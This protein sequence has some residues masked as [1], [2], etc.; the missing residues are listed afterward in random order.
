MNSLKN[1][2]HKNIY[3]TFYIVRAI[4]KKAIFLYVFFI[5]FTSSFT[6]FAFDVLWI[7]QSE[8]S[9]L[10]EPMTGAID[11][12]GL[13][14]HKLKASEVGKINTLQNVAKNEIAVVINAQALQHIPM[15]SLL[16]VIPQKVAILI[17]GINRETDSAALNEWSM[18]NIVGTDLQGI[19]NSYLNIANANWIAGPL[20]GQKIPIKNTQVN[21]LVTR[22]GSDLKEILWTGEQKENDPRLLMTKIDV[23]KREIFF[24]AEMGSDN[25]RFSILKVLPFFMFLKY[26]G[27][28]RSYHSDGYY[29]NLTIDDP[30]LI[31]PYGFLS[32]PELL[33]EMKKEN[34]HTTIAFIPWNYDRSR[35]DVI[36]II[37][38]HADLFSLCIHGNDHDHQEFYPDDEQSKQQKKIQ[39][40][41]ARMEAFKKITGIPYDRVMVFPHGMAPEMTVRMIQK[42]N[43]L[44]TI[45]AVPVPLLSQEFVGTLNG[46]I[47][48]K[49]Q[50]NNM[51]ILWGYPPYGRQSWE[52]GLDLF[53]GNPVLFYT[54][55]DFFETGMNAF[56]PI[57]R[58]VNIPNTTYN[59]EASALLS[60]TFI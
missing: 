49:S 54:H 44:A 19:A 51:P 33:Q 29:A 31:E 14:A 20:S 6:A 24:L 56:N 27:G 7:N 48:T 36:D 34:F 22:T 9:I 50:A 25:I 8:E 23:G 3:K 11:Y 41:L 57:A 10:N 40:A 38:S 15:K 37:R 4:L 58:L 39:Q 2:M 55:H 5:F 53:L 60:N 47:L 16:T 52:I 21:N 30:W 13:E 18:D 59:G 32:Y 42:F 46:I 1:Q 35:K 26:A 45:N 43:F 28:D 17:Y 12:Y